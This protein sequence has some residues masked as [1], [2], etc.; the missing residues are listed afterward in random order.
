LSPQPPAVSVIIPVFNEEKAIENTV[1]ELIPY[2][3]EHNWEVIVVNDG[4]NDNTKDIIDKIG[5]ITAIHHHN[6]KGYGAALRTGILTSDS[7]VVAF[8]DADGQHNPGDLLNLVNNFHDTDAIIG[9][10]GKQFYSSPGRAPGKWVLKKVAEMLGG[11]KIPDLN[12][13]LRVMRKDKMLSVL[14]LCPR[15]F[16]FSTTTTLSFLKAGYSVKHFPISVKKRIGHSNVKQVKHGIETILLIIRLI[17]LFDPMKVF[18][19]IAGVLIFSGTLYQIYVFFTFK[20]KIVGGAI[21]SI[22]AGLLIFFFGI[23]AD[24]ISE[25]RREKIETYFDR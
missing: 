22:M 10:R 12:S 20:W 5:E 16:S 19:P 25:M 14:H 13:G 15:G 4:S 1:N 21:L 7:P 6:N 11:Q 3:R 24:Q 8:Y 17:T 18:L 2:A 9:D 23:L